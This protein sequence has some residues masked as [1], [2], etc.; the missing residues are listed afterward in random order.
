[1]PGG[2]GD[3]MSGKLT[4][5]GREI[6]A[7]QD[8]VRASR[9]RA[10]TGQR[11]E[12]IH[13]ELGRRS[14]NRQGSP[15]VWFGAGALATAACLA[16]YLGTRPEPSLTASVSGASVGRGEVVRS[17]PEPMPIAFSDGTRLTLEPN[18][19]ARLDRVDAHGAEVF[20]TNGTL[21]ADVVPRTHGRWVVEAGPFEIL[22]TGTEFDAEWM[23]ASETLEVSLTEGSVRVSGDCLERPAEMRAGQAERFTCRRNVATESTPVSAAPSAPAPSESG[24][25]RAAPSAPAP[26]V[27]DAMDWKKQASEG[28]FKEA[29]AVAEA[30]GFS[31]LC[32][33]EDAA[34]VLELGNVARLAGKPGLAAQAYTSVRTNA[35]GTSAA[36][37]AAL[38]LGRMAFDGA[39]DFAAARRWFTVYLSES[40]GGPY[41]QEALGRLMEAEHKAGDTEAARR[42]AARYLAAYPGG[43]HAALA[44]SL[45]QEPA[46]SPIEE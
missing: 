26:L 21:H 38:Q 35:P 17:G 24:E 4:D 10:P 29:L 40:P 41:G 31:R 13:K 2:M 9:T 7:F 32:A 19:S 42:T 25:D 3:A 46:G 20:L 27:A 12:R 8:E 36:S 43:A 16:V 30:Q 34:S 15:L 18:S 39:G 11:L 1:M 23:P 14:V 28:H 37:T 33:T 6:A 5:L 45:E 44:R 22:V